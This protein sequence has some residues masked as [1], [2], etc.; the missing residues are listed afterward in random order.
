MRSRLYDHA[1]TGGLRNCAKGSL[2]GQVVGRG[3]CKIAHIYR[4]V[5]E[6]MV[7]SARSVLET[8]CWGGAR[9]W[10][11]QQ[12]VV[13]SRRQNVVATVNRKVLRGSLNW[14]RGES[15]CTACWKVKSPAAPGGNIS[16]VIGT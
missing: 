8:S 7:P 2:D 9:L 15:V 6:G 1:H 13:S 5:E 10:E 11:T 14:K 16:L 12:I 3:H 4:E